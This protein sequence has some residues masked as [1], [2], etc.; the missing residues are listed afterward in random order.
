MQSKT[1]REFIFKKLNYYQLQKTIFDNRIE[2]IQNAFE[3]IVKNIEFT[4]LSRNC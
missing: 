2:G 4:Q 3:K 1:D